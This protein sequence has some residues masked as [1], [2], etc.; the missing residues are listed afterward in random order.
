MISISKASETN[1]SSNPY[2]KEKLPMHVSN[3]ITVRRS[4]A[5]PRKRSEE[6]GTLESNRREALLSK[7]SARY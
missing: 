2:T 7:K 6:I 3:N 1:Q 5:N 4:G